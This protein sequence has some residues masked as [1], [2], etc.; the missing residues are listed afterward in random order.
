MSRQYVMALDEGST[1]A[2]AVLV[3]MQGRIVSEARNPVVPAF[4]H[5]G[6]VEL[7]PAA[8][9]QAQ[10]ASMEAAMAKLGATTDDIA[11]IG[12]TT[13]R[14]TCLIWDRQ[15]GEPVYPAIMWMSKQTDAIVARWKAEGLDQLV[16]Q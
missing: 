5:T 13:H 14:E 4:P 2:R 10:R 12:V 7:D 3:D 15:T 1:S 8:L 16:R 6:W 9:W 11:A